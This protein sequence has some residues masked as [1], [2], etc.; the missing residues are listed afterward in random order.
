MT[1]LY[2]MTPLDLRPNRHVIPAGTKLWRVHNAKYAPDEFNPTLADPFDP[3]RGSRFDGTPLDSYHSLYLADTETTAL[4]ESVLRSR[5]FEP[6]ESARLI[7]YAAVRGR[8]LSVLRTRCELSLVSLIASSDLAA[9]CQDAALLEDE[10]N[11]VQARHW[12]R[13][14]RAQSS[15]VM[16]LIW[17]S[18]HNRPRHVLVLFH[19]RFGHY[20]GKPFE[21]LPDD[22]IP[23]LGS[24]N[25]L[26]E[27]N[28]L[29]E[30]LRS[31]IS[32]P[33]WD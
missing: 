28:R 30:H 1:G 14:I 21:V 24:K 25:G 9:V 3:R 22:G 4:A 15:D 2:P 12:A 19:D 26:R 31:K 23:D 11:Y 8:S 33:R 32:E 5:P 20:D 10:A 27:A 6:A 7:P 29:L 18:R 16:G 17:Q 13:E